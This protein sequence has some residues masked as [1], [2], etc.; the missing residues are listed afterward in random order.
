[1][2]DTMTHTERAFYELGIPMLPK[3]P[4]DAPPSVRLA[5]LTS[6]QIEALLDWFEKNP[7]DKPEDY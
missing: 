4:K 5:S 3:T 2:A 6:D 7:S 1:M